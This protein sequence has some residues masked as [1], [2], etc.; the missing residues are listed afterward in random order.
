METTVGRIIFNESLP[1]GIPFINEQMT[2]KS[3]E[4]LTADLIIRYTGKEVQ[5]TLDEIKTLGFEYSTKSGIS[6]GMD[7]LVVPKEKGK[8]M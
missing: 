6:W 5:E 4:Q 8:L 7:D 2:A 3:L 1:D